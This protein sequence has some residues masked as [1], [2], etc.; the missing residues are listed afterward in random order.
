[1]RCALVVLA[2]L[3]VNACSNNSRPSD[4]GNIDASAQDAAAP[5][6]ATDSGTED[7]DEDSS[8]VPPP[9][10]AA[11]TDTA[12]TDAAQ[13]DIDDG[14]CEPGETRTYTCR[15]GDTVEWCVCDAGGAWDCL[16]DPEVLCDGPCDD[17][18]E[19]RL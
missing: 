11:P 6:D 15:F 10:D 3:F 7:T 1:M 4:P 8:S 16:P 17:G 18:S 14:E 19:P 13:P 2:C 12:P 9:P 5:E